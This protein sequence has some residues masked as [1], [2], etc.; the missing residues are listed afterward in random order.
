M[1]QKDLLQIN[2]LIEGK[3]QI[4][5]NLFKHSVISSSTKLRKQNRGWSQYGDV[6]KSHWFSKH[7]RTIFVDDVF[8][9]SGNLR[10]YF[11]SQNS[12][13]FPSKLIPL[14]LVVAPGLWFFIE[15][16]I[17]CLLGCFI[18]NVF[19]GEYQITNT[20][21]LSLYFKLSVIIISSKESFTTDSFQNLFIQFNPKRRD[22]IIWSTNT[23]LNIS[24]IQKGAH[25]CF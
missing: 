3:Q 19:N 9:F 15:N 23:G 18:T 17:E 6:S 12:C 2:N 14:F 5:S 8:F 21:S 13:Q 24:F 16:E 7:N 1:D 22:I 25:L 11:S 4:L 20:I 10:F